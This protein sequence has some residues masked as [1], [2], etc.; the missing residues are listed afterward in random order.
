MP[1]SCMQ[2]VDDYTSLIRINPDDKVALWNRGV[3]HDKLG[4]TNEAIADYSRV[5]ELDPD[6]FSA[7]YARA[8]EG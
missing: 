6:S 4:A 7:A 5:L 2:A 1:L 8:G 3:A